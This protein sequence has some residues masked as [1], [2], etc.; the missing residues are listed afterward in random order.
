MSLRRAIKRAIDQNELKLYYQ[1]IIELATN[2]IAGH[3][4]LIRW[5]HPVDELLMPI[6]FIPDCENDP[7][8]MVEICEFVVKQSWC[9]RPKLKGGFIS[10][11]VS[12][13]SLEQQRFWDVLEEYSLIGDRPS[14]FLEITERSLTNHKIIM[15][16]FMGTGGHGIGA[17]IDDF[18]V[19]YSGFIQV[20]KVLKMFPSTD[21]I[22]VKLDIEFARNLADRTYQWFIKSIVA[23]MRDC[24]DG[25]I[26]IIAEGIEHEWQCEIFKELG[27]K[28]G[29][30]WLWGKAE[31]TTT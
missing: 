15:P 30:G 4:A 21:Y 22:K 7:L 17:F 31:A 9:D 16:Y 27:V 8:T 1:P 25:E 2:E 28:F 10:V 20:A 13:K 14:L 11:N 24:P 6:D 23:S 3:E 18:G 5:H 12:P 26:E 19:E 29:Q